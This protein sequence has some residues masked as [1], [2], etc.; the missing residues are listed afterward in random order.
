MLHCVNHNLAVAPPRDEPQ[1]T[2]ILSNFLRKFG[3][4]LTALVAALLMKAEYLACDQ[5]T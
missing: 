5:S 4:F 3:R 2:Q 1:Q